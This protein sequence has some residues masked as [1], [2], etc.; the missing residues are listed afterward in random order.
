MFS[1][2]LFHIN[3][4]GEIEFATSLVYRCQAFTTMNLTNVSFLYSLS[5]ISLSTIFYVFIKWY[6]VHL[7]SPF[8]FW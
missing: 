8:G 1:T 3:M 2:H 7:L 6:V 4:N 5:S